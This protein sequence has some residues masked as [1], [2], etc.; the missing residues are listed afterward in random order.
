MC[1]LI[2]LRVFMNSSLSFGEISKGIELFR[3]FLS[4]N[5]IANLLKDKA[6]EARMLFVGFMDSI[7]ST[8]NHCHL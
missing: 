5:L 2:D 1:G 4:E 6:D 3:T 8:G 7:F